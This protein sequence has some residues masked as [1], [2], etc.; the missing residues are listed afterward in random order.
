[1]A[2]TFGETLEIVYHLP[3]K[4]ADKAIRSA[5]EVIKNVVKEENPELCTYE[6]CTFIAR[7]VE[8][9]FKHHLLG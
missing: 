3:D 6:V 7:Q 9:A 4:T 1:M 8:G 5:V 2:I